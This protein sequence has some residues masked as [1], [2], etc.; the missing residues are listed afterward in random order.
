M[1]R[2]VV[3]LYDNLDT[4]QTAVQELLNN[5][6]SRDDVS[7]VRTNQ[8]GDYTSGNINDPN[9]MASSDAS[10]AAAGAGIGAVLG[11]LAG[12]LVGLGALAIPGIGPIIAAGP[13]ATTLAGAGL[14]A[15]TGGLVGALADAGI[16]EGDAGAYAEGVRRGG[17]LVT[18]RVDEDRVSLAT[19]VL[20]R[21]TPVDINERTTEW[22]SAGW[23]GFDANA[24]PY[25]TTTGA[26]HT[27]QYSGEGSDT[28]S[29]DYRTHQGMTGENS[30]GTYEGTGSAGYTGSGTIYQGGGS[31]TSSTGE[32]SGDTP[33]D[34]PRQSNFDDRGSVMSSGHG[35]M[36][37]SKG[38]SGQGGGTYERMQNTDSDVHP[39]SS[40][41]DYQARRDFLGGDESLDEGGRSSASRM[42]DTGH[43]TYGA[44][45]Q[46]FEADERH[47]MEGQLGGHQGALAGGG[48]LTEGQTYTPD[49]SGTNM[50]TTGVTFRGGSRFEDHDPDFR[51]DWGTN[52]RATGFDYERYQPAYQY[53]WQLGSRYPDRDWND[54]ES[55]ARADWERNQPNDAWQDFKAAVRTGWERFKQSAQNV[56]GGDRAGSQDYGRTVERSGDDVLQGGREFGNEMRGER[57]EIGHDL[58][59]GVTR[60][61]EHYDHDFRSN[62]EQS[63]R[64]TGYGYERYQ[65]AYQYGYTVGS[66]RRYRGRRWEEVEADVRRDWEQ[67]HPNDAWDDFKDAVRHAWQRVRTDV[68][69]VID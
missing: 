44:Q 11:G 69:D 3:A 21:Y 42:I 43:G 29:E 67:R 47:T 45:G 63:F 10:G 16:P 51:S 13:I 23:S 40:E 41:G 9:A 64:S 32:P 25:S 27:H 24:G 56:T 35:D 59:Q 34:A 30:G 65:P 31:Y 48:H 62:W 6:F 36:S 37:A 68:R 22:R 52:Y 1:E 20:G 17:T 7:V 46:N 55:E 57:R 61:F 26:P 39:R 58:G 18:V 2:T 33:M 38:S 54:F 53:G 49:T 8:H 12:L 5:G 28:G 4:A 19:E 60:G 15:A 50:G 66:E 14:G